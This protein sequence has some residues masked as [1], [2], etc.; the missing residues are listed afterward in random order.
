MNKKIIPAIPAAK[1]LALFSL[2]ACRKVCDEAALAIF[3]GTK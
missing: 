2:F 1:N 3:E